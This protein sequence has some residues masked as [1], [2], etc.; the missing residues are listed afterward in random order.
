[1]EAEIDKERQERAVQHMVVPGFAV[2]KVPYQLAQSSACFRQVLLL[3]ANPERVEFIHEKQHDPAY[4]E[5]P[6]IVDAALV[7][8]QGR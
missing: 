6:V 5:R 2:N 7:K 3:G 1:M 4:P 8:K